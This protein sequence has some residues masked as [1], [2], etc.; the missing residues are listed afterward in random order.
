MGLMKHASFVMLLLVVTQ[1]TCLSSR[2]RRKRDQL[3]DTELAKTKK[4]CT[5]TGPR[6]E[7]VSWAVKS[8]RIECTQATD[9]EGESTL[10]QIKQFASAF[11]VTYVQGRCVCSHDGHPLLQFAPR[12]KTRAKKRQSWDQGATA[13][14]CE[15]DDK[16]AK[17]YCWS[18]YKAGRATNITMHES[19]TGD[20]FPIAKKD[21]AF[22]QKQQLCCAQR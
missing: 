1:P 18:Y 9:W 14:H 16:I 19:S 10:N 11:H 13:E 5:I 22:V 17:E 3:V 20:S 12:T 7:K 4:K 21:M 8:C 15:A 2:V 6:G